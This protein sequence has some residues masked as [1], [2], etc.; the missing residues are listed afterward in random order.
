[1]LKATTTIINKAVLHARA[2]AKMVELTGRLES[3]VQIGHEKM[4]D[5]KSI[6]SLMM[7]AA[8]RGTE[9]TIEVDGSDEE[10]AMSAILAL[11]ENRFDEAE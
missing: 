10:R 6:L 9:L 11:I 4:V 8:V 1:M 2:A 7:L 5:G 3:A